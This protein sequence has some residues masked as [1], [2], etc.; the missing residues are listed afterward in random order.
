MFQLIN[1]EPDQASVEKQVQQRKSSSNSEESG[2]MKHTDDD[3]KQKCGKK[4]KM[5]CGSAAFVPQSSSSTKSTHSQEMKLLELTKSME[6]KLAKQEE[7]DEVYEPPEEKKKSSKKKPLQQSQSTTSQKKDK[8]AAKAKVDDNFH[9]G[10][11]KWAKY[12]KKEK[13]S[14]ATKK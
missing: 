8:D 10:S 5:D 4:M 2:S 14:G 7:S 6:S 1:E 12:K 13:G 11:L 3:Q 9:I